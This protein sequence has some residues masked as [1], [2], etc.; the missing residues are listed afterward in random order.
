MNELES[1]I[2]HHFGISADE[3]QKVS[4]LFKP[5]VVEK[6]SYFLQTGKSCN[7]LSF[8][9]SG[10]LR[11][12]VNLLDK[13]VTQW[14][15]TAG[16]FMTDLRGFMFRETSRFDI[17]ALTETH[18]YTIDYETYL[19]IGRL[20]PKWH[21]FEKLFMGKCF[22]MMENRILDLISMTAEKRYQ[23][24]FSENRELFNQVPLQY[25][26]SMLGMTPETFS[27]IRRK[28]VS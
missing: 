12:F 20:V 8:I 15:G 27:R 1:Y 17:Q 14:I 28:M 5:E 24:F 3:C 18:L 21:E 2:N 16:Y 11:V 6:G 23:K 7:K 26:A 10:I 4:E 19:T 22:V 25:L 9:E 13:E